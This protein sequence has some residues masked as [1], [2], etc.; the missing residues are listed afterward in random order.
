MDKLKNTI[1][2]VVIGCLCCMSFIFYGFIVNAE[3][4]ANQISNSEYDTYTDEDK[5][6]GYSADI[7]DYSNNLYATNIKPVFNSDGQLALQNTQKDDPITGVVPK[8]L[9]SKVG[10]TLHIG[11]E[12]GFFINTE[13]LEDNYLSNVLVFDIITNTDF[14]ETVDRVVISVSPIFQYSF[15]Y[16]KA[17]ENKLLFENGYELNYSIT[18]DRVIPYPSE[19]NNN[20]LEF[21]MSE[22]YYLKDISYGLSLY[23]ENNL[24]ASDVGYNPYNDKGSFFTAVDYTYKGRAREYGEFPLEETIGYGLD[25][26]QAF[27]GSAGDIIGLLRDINGVIQYGG[28]LVDWAFGHEVEVS[29]GKLRTTCYYQNRDDQLNNYKD[30]NGNPTLVKTAGMIVNTPEDKSIWYGV[31]DDVTGYF[32]VSHSALNGDVVEYTRLIREIGLKIVSVDGDTVVASSDSSYNEFLRNRNTKNVIDGKVNL[33]TIEQAYDKFKFLPTESEF[34]SFKNAGIYTINLRISDGVNESNY[35]QIGKQKAVRIYL[36]KTKTYTVEVGGIESENK[37]HSFL[38][39]IKLDP[40][41]IKSGQNVSGT[42]GSTSTKWYQFNSTQNDVSVFKTNY[43]ERI[44]IYDENLE[45][46]ASANEGYLEI[47]SLANQKYYIKISKLG[48]VNV[49][50]F[51]HSYKSDVDHEQDIGKYQLYFLKFN[52]SVLGKYELT[53]NTSLNSLDIQLFNTDYQLIKETKDKKFDYVFDYIGQYIVGIKNSTSG[54]DKLKF[55]YVLKTNSVYAGVNILEYY[56]NLEYNF[57]SFTPITTSI[58]DFSL[59]EGNCSV[60]E[61]LVNTNDLQYT[62]LNAGEVYYVKVSSKNAYPRLTIKLNEYTS[63]ENNQLVKGTFNSDEYKFYKLTTKQPGLYTIEVQNAQMVL[64]DFNL[65]TVNIYNGCAFTAEENSEYYLKL[66]GRNAGNYTVKYYFDPIELE[67]NQAKVIVQDTY[68]Q[69]KNNGE[70]HYILKT[71]GVDS[72]KTKIKYTTDLVNFVESTNTSGHAELEVNCNENIFY[73][74]VDI[75]GSGYAGVSI[76]YENHDDYMKQKYELNEAETYGMN[77]LRLETKNFSFNVPE[78]YLGQKFEVRLMKNHFTNFQLAFDGKLVECDDLEDGAVA[79]FIIEPTIGNHIISL[80]YDCDKNIVDQDF[81]SLVIIKKVENIDMYLTEV[82][83]GNVVRDGIRES[84]EFDIALVVNGEIVYNDFIVEHISKNPNIQNHIVINGTRLIALKGLPFNE[85]AN[86]RINYGF[87]NYYI[88]VNIEYPYLLTA[89]I[90]QDDNIL[91]YDIYVR[92]FYSGELLENMSEENTLL[93]FYIKNIKLEGN[94]DNSKVL[95]ES[96]TNTDKDY[97]GP[98]S[99]DL[100]D[101]N[102]YNDVSVD[103]EIVLIDSSSK[104]LATLIIKYSPNTSIENFNPENKK[105]IYLDLSDKTYMTEYDFSPIK[106]PSSVKVVNVKG[107]GNVFAFNG[108][109]FA[110]DA[111]LNL[112]NITL[113]GKWSGVPVKSDHNLTVN[114][115]GDV[116]LHGC[117]GYF[118]TMQAMGTPALKVKNLTIEIWFG[119]TLNVEGGLPF[120]ADKVKGQKGRTGN[121]GSDGTD[122]AR[123]GKVGDVGGTG[124]DGQRGENGTSGLVCEI[125]SLD[126]VSGKL[127]VKGSRGGNGGDG[128]DG[129]VGG[130]GGNG[131]S[132][133]AWFQTSGNGGKGGKGG[134][135]GN[136]GNGGNGGAAVEC[137]QIVGTQTNCTFIGGA[138]GNAGNGGAGGEGGAGGIGGSAPFLGHA[139]SN[140]T[141]GEEGDRGNRGTKG[142]EGVSI[143]YV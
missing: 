75:T 70:N 12:Y 51:N 122:S 137:K 121:K 52:I 83:T 4:R 88:Q 90:K 92:D 95:D 41:E 127:E 7:Q 69:F 53:F 134:K 15:A 117:D 55:D 110:D 98:I 96:L 34:Y 135:G 29:T 46:Y 86:F 21:N 123:D 141:K 102:Y 104:F 112:Y 87:V 19:I 129:G 101:L 80:R 50:S 28:E 78:S 114:I 8:E 56:Q 61:S 142:S 44:D 79:R 115:L 64:F 2:V 109:E 108:F 136:G 54:S 120:Y 71:F 17:G 14:V 30:I 107:N 65:E 20:I 37:F 27:M 47:L 130:V 16:I 105:I 60:L 40:E 22:V 138:A 140:G 93:H 85:T 94:I 57:Y 81:V 113:Y 106:I 82:I 74:F 118:G 39:V 68:F 9:F 91:C 99:F 25:V 49:F 84:H 139:G 36:D 131:F 143:K 1:L 128:G 6:I 63:L 119:G 100:L 26:V 38:M 116:S 76:E 42:F 73:V 10:S 24:N 97:N 133:S 59:D 66:I 58:Y 111:V 11:K 67:I 18:E 132:T 13:N 3:S 125:L 33:Y 5:I 45:Y 48:S 62:R 35:T 32:T 126:V 31:G 43:A 103:C 23:N 89:E 72:I 124:N 77:F